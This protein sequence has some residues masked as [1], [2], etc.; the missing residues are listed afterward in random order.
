[1][2]YRAFKQYIKQKLKSNY[3][4]ECLIL[5]LTPAT[6]LLAVTVG[7]SITFNDSWFPDRDQTA[8][9]L[10]VFLLYW[11]PLPLLCTLVGAVFYSAKFYGH[12][13]IIERHFGYRAFRLDM[14]QQEYLA[15]HYEGDRKQERIIA[16]AIRH[17]D[18]SIWSV[19]RPG[20]HHH[21]I[22]Y[23]WEHGENKKAGQ[24]GFLTNRYRFIGREEARALAIENGQCPT[25]DH[26]R[27]L[28]SED[29]WETP[30]HLQ[31]KG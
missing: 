16:S 19:L 1:V 4:G 17:R 26:S 20:R 3:A 28:F 7:A 5:A 13:E 11:L 25:P 6:F 21:C 8:L 12:F 31:Y 18:G 23:M 24:Q 15:M 14:E 29:L 2:I 10:G 27:D 30:L 22:A 9:L